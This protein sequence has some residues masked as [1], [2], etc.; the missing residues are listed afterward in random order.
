MSSLALMREEK[1]FL[2][3]TTI[4]LEAD[5]KDLEKTLAFREILMREMEV[6]LIKSQEISDIDSSRILKLESDAKSLGTRLAE[7]QALL[8]KSNESDAEKNIQIE[9]LGKNLNAASP[10]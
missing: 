1:D 4:Q 5:K 9:T 6:E 3:D 7:L 10:K 8:D 2:S